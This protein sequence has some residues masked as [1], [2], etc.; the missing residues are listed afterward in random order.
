M[1]ADEISSCLGLD[2]DECV[3]TLTYDVVSFIHYFSND[4]S[5]NT[6]LECNELLFLTV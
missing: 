2:F 5:S 6:R 4:V 1:G 3:G